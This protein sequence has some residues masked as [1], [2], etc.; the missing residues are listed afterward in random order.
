[1]NFSALLRK[2]NSLIR[3]STPK[4]APDPPAANL[5]APTPP[6][7]PPSLIPPPCPPP[8]ATT[9]CPLPT[10]ETH[11]ELRQETPAASLPLISPGRASPPPWPE[12]KSFGMSEHNEQIARL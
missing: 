5:P 7:P 10:P 2:W 12:R 4:P 3:R 8:P 6:S 1:M 11:Q 9:S